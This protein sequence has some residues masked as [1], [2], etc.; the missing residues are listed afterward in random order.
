MKERIQMEIGAMKSISEVWPIAG[1]IFQQIKEVSRGIF[2]FD[3]QNRNKPSET[4]DGIQDDP[5]AFIHD[6]F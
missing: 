3:P 4:F 6:E 1:T 2:I 5:S